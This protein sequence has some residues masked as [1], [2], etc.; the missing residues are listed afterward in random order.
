MTRK[1]L[2]LRDERKEA[3]EHLIAASAL[4]DHEYFLSLWN[5]DAGSLDLDGL[6]DWRWSG[7]EEVLIDLLLLIAG[8]PRPVKVLDLW[9]LDEPNRR[10][11]VTA[12]DIAMTGATIATVLMHP[13]LRVVKR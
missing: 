13:A 8:Y 5:P 10:A 7:G 1:E 3:L 12:L 11:A 4:G 6:H 2:H 9:Q